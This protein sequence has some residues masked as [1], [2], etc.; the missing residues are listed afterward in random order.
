MVT[1]SY[2]DIT[3]DHLFMLVM[4]LCRSQILYGTAVTGKRRGTVNA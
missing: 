2:T 4:A 1:D 3:T